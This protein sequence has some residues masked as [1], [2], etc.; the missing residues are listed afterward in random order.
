[1]SSRKRR[2]TDAD[3]D[4]TSFM[5]LMVILIPFL[6]L[7]AV[8]TQV[9]VLQVSLP[10]D[11]GG[12]AGNEPKKPLVLEVMVYANRLIVADRQTGPLK[13]IADGAD[14]HDFKAL[15]DYLREVKTQHP[16]ITEATVLLEQ[17]TSYNNLIQTMDAVRII[18]SEV[19]G[20]PTKYALFPDVGIGDAPM[21]PAKGGA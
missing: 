13:T 16:T 11:G 21:D 18:Q 19:N 12:A 6:L 5:N 8:F 20:K 17:E 4:I 9:A 14:G 2:G 3:L 10:K 7:N 1:M 15:N